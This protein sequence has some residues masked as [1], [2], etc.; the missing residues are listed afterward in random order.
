[1]QRYVVTALGEILIDELKT[2]SDTVSNVGGAPANFARV[3]A[4]M[5]LKSAFLGAVGD[6]IRGRE[7]ILALVGDSV[8]PLCSVK[9][10]ATTVALVTLDGSGER[11]F[12]FVRA[13]GFGNQVLHHKFGHGTAADVA[14]TNKYYFHN[15]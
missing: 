3:A 7:C 2:G 14:V 1:M 5:G 8:E 12:R 4:R 9:R 15:H 13:A 11:D 10:A 6:D